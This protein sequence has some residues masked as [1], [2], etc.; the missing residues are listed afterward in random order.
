VWRQ[1]TNLVISSTL[2]KRDYAVSHEPELNRRIRLLAKDSCRPHSFRE[3]LNT[4]IEL[5]SDGV[6]S[7]LNLWQIA[8]SLLLNY[9]PVTR[10]VAYNVQGFLQC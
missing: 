5:I 9:I 2:V 4:V 3:S 10:K 8:F 7:T 1:F 6:L